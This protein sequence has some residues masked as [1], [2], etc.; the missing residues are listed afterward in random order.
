MKHPPKKCPCC[1]STRYNGKVCKRCHFTNLE[2]KEIKL[3]I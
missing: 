1:M 2:T 3:N